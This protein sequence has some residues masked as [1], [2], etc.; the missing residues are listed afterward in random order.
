FRSPKPVRKAASKGGRPMSLIARQPAFLVA[1]GAGA[2]SYG[3]MNLLMA[4][5]PLAMQHHGLPF[6]DAAFVL[7]WHVIGMFAPGF[8]TGHLIDRFGVLN[9]MGAG[10]ALNLACVAIALS[11][12]ELHHITIY[13]FLLGVG[14]KFLLTCWLYPSLSA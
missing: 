1:A 3:I 6:S 9:V 12:V 13:L 2:L 7:E 11:G 5:T 4:G 10:V 14:W 8:F